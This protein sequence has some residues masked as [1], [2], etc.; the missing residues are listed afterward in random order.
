MSLKLYETTIIVKCQVKR[1]CCY[2]GRL[3]QAVPMLSASLISC[4]PQL[5][6]Q[7]RLGQKPTQPD[8]RC[9]RCGVQPG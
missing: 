2:D 1:Q 9:P 4:Q 7:P 6:K 5:M 8:I 3:V